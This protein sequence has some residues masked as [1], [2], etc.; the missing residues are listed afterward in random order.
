MGALNKIIILL[1]TDDDFQSSFKTLLELARSPFVKNIIGDT[2]D[3]DQVELIVQSLLTDDVSSVSSK[4]T[5]RECIFIFFAIFQT[6]A[7]VIQTIVNILECFSVDR[8]V[9]VPSEVEME[10]LA[11]ELN[12]KKLFY[13]GIFFNNVSRVTDKEY[14]YKLRMDVDNIPI[15]LENRNRF[16]FPGPSAS[17]ELDMKYHRGFIQLQYAIDRAIIKTIRHHETLRLNEERAE[18]TTIMA[19][20][21]YSSENSAE[22][23]NSTQSDV[24]V[25]TTMSPEP[26]NETA[27]ER[28]INNINIS[29]LNIQTFSGHG[30]EDFLNFKNDGGSIHDGDSQFRRKRS[31]LDILDF[32]I[33]GD[34]DAV[35]GEEF[36]FDEFEMY[37]KQFPYPKYKKDTYVT[38]IYLAQAIQMT[39][40]FALIVQVSAAVRQRIW[41]KESGN[42][43]VNEQFKLYCT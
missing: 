33:F 41:T 3:I 10:R 17:F 12:E 39:F 30:S 23:S 4:L 27:T 7:N 35:E 34:S 40:F 1:R 26:I 36:H 42:S 43:T 20:Y 37:T 6:V 19:D 9:S 24:V 31:A 21:E 16:W 25:V 2:V 8:F 38:G 14:S 5:V 28:N 29:T 32:D 13:S 11:Y 22:V 15:T 18:M